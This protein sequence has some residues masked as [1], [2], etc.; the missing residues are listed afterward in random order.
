MSTNR[1]DRLS[2]LAL[3]NGDKQPTRRAFLKKSAYLAGLVAAP[4]S[5]VLG[6]CIQPLTGDINDDCKVD[7]EDLKIMS[8]DWLTCNSSARS[9]LDSA[10]SYIQDSAC[11]CMQDSACGCIQDSA[12]SYMQNSACGCIHDS[13]GSRIYV[14]FRDFSIMAKD[15]GKCGLV[16]CQ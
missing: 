14:D 10:F 13:A 12:C 15:W 6:E 8:S 2:F 1:S 3:L 7:L 16:E 11:G 5:R 4:L 9:N